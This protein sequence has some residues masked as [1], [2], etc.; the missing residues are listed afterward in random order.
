MTT[1]LLVRHGQTAT[2]GK[3]LTGRTAGVHLTPA[4]REQADG[5][6]GRLDGTRIDAIVSSP[7]ERCRETAAPLARARGLRVEVDRDLAELDVGAWV[8]RTLTSLSRTKLWPRVQF[9]PSLV[10]FPDG[11]SFAEAQHRTVRALTRIADERP[12]ATVAV[13]SH[14]DIIKLALAY[15]AGAP[16]DVFQRFSVDT[17]SVSTVRIAGGLPMITGT[18]VSGSVR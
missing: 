14:A 11:E 18:N 4:G 17:A 2:A 5:L 6:V 7:L 3:R 9:A 10:R 13:F 15:F 8:G 12:R 16:L 1:L